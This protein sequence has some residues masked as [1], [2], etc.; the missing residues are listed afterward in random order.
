LLGTGNGITNVGFLFGVPIAII[1]FAVAYFLGVSATDSAGVWCTTGTTFA[2]PGPAIILAITMRPFIAFRT[3]APTIHIGFRAIFQAVITTDADAR[4]ALIGGT[5][6]PF[7]AGVAIITGCTL[8]PTIRIGF[9][10][11]FNAIA[12]AGTDP[13]GTTLG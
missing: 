12:T 11:I 9:S 3:I 6:V 10:A 1:I 5:I 7:L 8:T 13:P 4:N 2:C